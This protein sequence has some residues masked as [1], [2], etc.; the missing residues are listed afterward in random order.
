MNYQ[1]IVFPMLREAGEELKKGF[2]KAEVVHQKSDM[3]VDVVTDLDRKTE[4]FLATQLRRVDSS[5]DFYG[6][7]NGGNDEAERQ[8]ILIQTMSAGFEYAMVASGKLEG[9]I[10]LDAYGK[11]WD[12]A[13]GSLLISEAGGI[14]TNIGKETYDYRNLNAIAT[15]PVIYRE[16]T[17]GADAIFPIEEVL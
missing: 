5:I 15:N 7:E 1:K 10:T 3:A 4:E 2:G 11:I 8:C 14:V 12:Y 17:Q 6:E 9:R 16:L 13:P